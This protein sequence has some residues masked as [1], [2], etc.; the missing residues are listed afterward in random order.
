MKKS[1]LGASLVIGTVLCGIYIAGLA[2]F[3]AAARVKTDAPVFPRDAI[4]V[5]T[6][7]N[8]RVD[9]GFNLLE[10][11]L[12]KKL[13]ISGVSRGTGIK[14]LLTR[15]KE[16]PQSSLDCCVVLGFEASNTVGNA[17]E[18]VAWMKQ[19]NYRSIYLVTAN[20]HIA[21]AMMEFRRADPEIDIEPVPVFPD[22]IVMENWWSDKITRNM[23]LREYSKYALLNVL[24]TLEDL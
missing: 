3:V 12:G 5:L 6:G 24:Y 17:H 1:L 20:Y 19:E 8:S 9:A 18:T 23:I 4:V 21:R 13:F 16:E 10:Q 11:K 15:W 22:G 14:S 7:G 2:S